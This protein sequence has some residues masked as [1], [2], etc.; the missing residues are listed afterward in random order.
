MAVLG[1]TAVA[2]EPRHLAEQHMTVISDGGGGAAAG[3]AGQMIRVV[4]LD[5]GPVK[6]A[7][8]AAEATNETIQILQD[9]NRIVEKQ[10]SKMYRDAEGRTR[11]ENNFSTLGPLVPEGAAP[12]IT[13][14]N[15]PVSGE[16]FVLDNN[17]K[18]ATK[19]TLPKFATMAKPGERVEVNMEMRHTGPNTVA[20]RVEWHALAPGEAAPAGASASAKGSTGA[21]ATVSTTVVD[22]RMIA[23]PAVMEYK[24]QL[25]LRRADRMPGAV[26]LKRESLGKQ[27]IEGVEC[28]GTR[29]TTT[30]PAGQIGN[31]RPLTSVTERWF[32][33]KLQAD[34]LRKYT[35]PRFGETN[36]RLTRI[37]Q[38]DQPR[39][40][41]EVPA[42]YKLEDGPGANVMF[43]R[44]VNKD[45]KE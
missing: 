42:D 31:E 10:T 28:D 39:S 15:D 25:D 2:Q 43:N 37:V 33:E 41:F 17:R 5:S 11:M 21:T 26:D 30:I 1:L 35:D 18:T 23:G 16:H 8:Y 19:M 27:V 20:N 22:D 6:G 38:A 34:V 3:A 14:I 32:S 29:E 9:G 24:Q 4:Q 44:R 36:Y 12:S 40:L 13:S 7:P 45:V